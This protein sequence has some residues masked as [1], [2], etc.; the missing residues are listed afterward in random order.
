MDLQN[1]KRRELLAKARDKKIKYYYKMRKKDL[2]D[3]L[4]AYQE[5]DEI[6]YMKVKDLRALAKDQK[7]KY[8]YK[9]TKNQLIDKLKPIKQEPIEEKKVFIPTITEKENAIKGFFKTFSIK[10]ES[11]IDPDSFLNESNSSIMDVLEKNV[12]KGIN[13]N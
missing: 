12:E 7:V 11:G 5:V 10:G 4:N 9:L 6:Y 2:I 13:Q 8:Y 3:A 1:L